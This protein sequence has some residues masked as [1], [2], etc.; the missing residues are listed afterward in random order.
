MNIDDTDKEGI[1]K[2]I[3][4]LPSQQP[5][6]PP[7]PQAS[8][9]VATPSPAQPTNP[10]VDA[11]QTSTPPPAT[12]PMPTEPTPET[13]VSSTPAVSGSD[14]PTP[15]TEQL[16]PTQPMTP[17][18]TQPIPA[19]G[20]LE[21]T[22]VGGV[23]EDKPKGKLSKMLLRGLGVLAF[24]AVIAIVGFFIMRSKQVDMFGNLVV[25]QD[26][27]NSY[28]LLVPEKYATTTDGSADGISFYDEKYGLEDSI[29]VIGADYFDVS[30]KKI[31][32]SE[33]DAQAYADGYIDSYKQG[34]E[35]DNSVSNLKIETTTTKGT[36][37][38]VA[39]RS[40]FKTTNDKGIDLVVEQFTVFNNQGD[41]VVVSVAVREDYH[42][43][44]AD[45]ID[46]IFDSVT[47]ET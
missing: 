33:D 28:S 40:S 15:M 31:I 35:S 26:P 21:H 5:P 32:T 22:T 29:A 10:T 45:A 6:I 42:D 12:P 2:V 25:Y 38:G 19:P 16:Q 11:P 1:A 36:D 39:I 20:A 47:L 24:F 18:Q 17:G 27:T 8:D 7:N 46:K 9:T 44:I 37:L 41:A 43:D 4:D 3:P 14:Q 34:F 23:D 13:P 30:D